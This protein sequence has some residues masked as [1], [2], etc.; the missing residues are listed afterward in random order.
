MALLYE[1]N[2]RRRPA[3]SSQPR[4]PCR[5]LFLW[6]FF[7][8]SLFSSFLLIC[9]PPY[10]LSST[11]HVPSLGFP[12]LLLIFIFFSFD[13]TPLF[14]LFLL[15]LLFLLPFFLFFAFSLPH[16]LNSSSFLPLFLSF[17]I[18]VPPLSQFLLCSPPFSFFFL[19]FVSS[20]PSFKHT[21]WFK[22]YFWPGFLELLTKTQ[23]LHE[24]MAFVQLSWRLMC[25]L[26]FWMSCV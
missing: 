10:F 8:L 9:P 7:S 23:G 13:P 1:Y 20:S 2:W 15:S 12:P 4:S 25:C 26:C 24:Q 11:I 3:A 14:L 21:S 6:L 18:K 17:S 22:H 16:L 5:S 19:R